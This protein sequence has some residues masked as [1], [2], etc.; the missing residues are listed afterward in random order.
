[1]KAKKKTRKQLF[2]M[3]DG[4]LAKLYDRFV[5]KHDPNMEDC[6]VDQSIVWAL[7]SL[8]DW[9]A[10]QYDGEA[11]LKISRVLFK[12]AFNILQDVPKELV[13]QEIHRVA[14]MSVQPRRPVDPR[15]N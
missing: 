11:R 9:I 2:K 6:A 4:Q 14:K 12:L 15:A 5:A 10:D 3:F 7:C 13:V 1:M 8:I